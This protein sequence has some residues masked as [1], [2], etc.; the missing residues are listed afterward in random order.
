MDNMFMGLTSCSKRYCSLIM[1]ITE[2]II[3]IFNIKGKVISANSAACN[4]LGYE[5][6]EING[7]SLMDIFDDTFSVKAFQN[8]SISGTP[9]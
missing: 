7:I 6:K 4:K 2:E 1:D 3:I 9:I 5:P 8:S